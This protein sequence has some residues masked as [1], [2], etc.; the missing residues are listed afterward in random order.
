MNEGVYSVENKE[1]ESVEEGLGHHYIHEMDRVHELETKLH[2]DVVQKEPHSVGWDQQKRDLRGP[3]KE[4]HVEEGVD[5]ESHFVTERHP[6]TETGERREEEEEAEKSGEECEV[7]LKV[8]LIGSENEGQANQ[9][10]NVGE[11]NEDEFVRG[12]GK[13]ES[14]FDGVELSGGHGVGKMGSVSKEGKEH[15]EEK[16]AHYS[17][18]E[19]CFFVEVLVECGVVLGLSEG[20]D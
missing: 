12:E 16:H 6:E 2:H 9:A 14:L 13:S 19:H 11:H 18:N 1:R 20:K 7:G 17:L 4:N 3:Q 8:G 5:E 10:D 15:S